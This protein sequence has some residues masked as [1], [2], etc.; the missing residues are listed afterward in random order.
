MLM[1]P[2]KFRFI[3]MYKNINTNLYTNDEI[4]SYDWVLCYILFIIT[5]LYRNLLSFIQ[6]F[7]FIICTYNITLFLFYSTA[8]FV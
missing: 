4:L 2:I 1:K 5:K 7:I 6:K 8:S 3:I